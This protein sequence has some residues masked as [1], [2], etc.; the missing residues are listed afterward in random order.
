[1]TAPYCYP[2]TGK[3]DRLSIPA[4]NSHWVLEL[5]IPMHDPETGEARTAV[6]TIPKRAL[7]QTGEG[8]VVRGVVV[9]WREGVR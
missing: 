2:V 8:R 6:V 9:R 1:M 4:A 7:W 3:P 5:S